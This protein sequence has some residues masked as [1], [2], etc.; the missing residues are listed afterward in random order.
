MLFASKPNQIEMK[1]VMTDQAGQAQF[2]LV[3]SEIKLVH[4]TCYHS[5]AW[6]RVG[7]GN[8]CVEVERIPSKAADY[9]VFSSCARAE[10]PLSSLKFFTS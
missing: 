1:R 4:A 6:W 10:I 2:R 9:E 8:T 7:S 5:H 3:K